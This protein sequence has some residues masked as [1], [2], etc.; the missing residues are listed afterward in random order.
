MRRQCARVVQSH[1]SSWRLSRQRRPA[2]ALLPRVAGAALRSVRFETAQVERALQLMHGDHLS[3]R[4]R[5]AEQPA[6]TAF[7][8]GILTANSVEGARLALRLKKLGV[9]GVAPPTDDSNARL[10]FGSYEN[11]AM[12]EARVAQL[13]KTGVEATI[14][15][16]PRSVPT[17]WLDVD[18][19]PGDRPVDVAAIQATVGGGGALV[20]EDC[21]HAAPDSA[22]APADA[23]AKS[24][25]GIAVPSSA[26]APAPAK[27]A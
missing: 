23:P 10:T 7:V 25:A 24:P 17:S 21:P 9:E 4:Q 12:A 19:A 5:S 22:P 27:P 14:S 16:E 18:L 1:R 3:P 13:R 26:P 15:E 11:H 6:G 2:Q 20:L 8:V